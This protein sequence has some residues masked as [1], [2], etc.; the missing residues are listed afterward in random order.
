M[1]VIERIINDNIS[2]S[3]LILAYQAQISNCMEELV[4]EILR[5][6]HTFGELNDKL[7]KRISFSTGIDCTALCTKHGIT[8]DITEKPS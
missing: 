4:F 3:S 6:F 8:Y 7:I 2:K 1:K 5:D